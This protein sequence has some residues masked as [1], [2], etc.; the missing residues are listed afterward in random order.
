M[1]AVCDEIAN[2][3]EF[4]TA[5]GGAQFGDH[6][7]WQAL[8]EYQSLLGD[9]IGMDV[10]STPTYDWGAAAGQRDPD[11]LQV[12]GAQRGS[13]SGQRQRG[14]LLRSCTTSSGRWPPSAGSGWTRSRA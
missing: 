3:S 2:R 13:R 8:F 11:G 10:V 12:Y 14:P 7:K 9:L 4:V 6:G 5:Y 1:P